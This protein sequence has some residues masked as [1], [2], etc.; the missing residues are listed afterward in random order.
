MERKETVDAKNES[1][2]ESPADIV[3]MAGETTAA[4]TSDTGEAG[5]ARPVGADTRVRV[6]GE[7]DTGEEN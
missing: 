1:F 3:E 2:E 4:A 5:D 6:E 7:E